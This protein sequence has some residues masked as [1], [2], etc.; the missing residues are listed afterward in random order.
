ML[1]SQGKYEEAESMNRQTLARREKVLGADHPDTLMSVYCLAHLLANQHRYDESV[2][3]YK[4]A[5][6]GYSTVLGKDHRTT[7]ACR[8]H[9]SKMLAS[10]EQDELGRPPKIP[11]NSVIVHAGKGSRLSRGLEDIQTF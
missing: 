2:V 6:A 5:C 3:L 1:G 11:N 8:Q 10:Q 4:R 7:H 9:Y